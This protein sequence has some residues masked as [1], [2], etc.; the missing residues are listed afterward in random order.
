[1]TSPPVSQEI[2]G[3][4][5]SYFFGGTGPSHSKLTTAFLQGGYG[6]AC[7]YNVADGTP[8]KEIRVQRTI[9]AAVRK[10][11]RARGLVEALL[12]QLRIAGSFDSERTDFD[13]N[14]FRTLRKAFARQ[15]WSLSDDGELSPISGLDLTT[16]GRESLDEQLT[17]IRKATDDPG[18]LL[19]ASKDLL[20]AVAKFVLEE[21]GMAQPKSAKFPQLWHLSRERLGILPQQVDTTIPGADAIRHILQSAW[22]IA[23][24]VNV[25]RGLQGTGHGR[26]LP[27]GVSQELAL[28]VVREACSVA[29]FMLT[30]LDRQQGRRV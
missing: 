2:A 14:A 12:V 8:N 18:A 24:Q 1:M 22:T 10:P 26:T 17:R 9:M 6:D 3:A 23:D 15:G 19:G 25:L 21:V 16:G 13:R 4:F 29:E 27:T 5:A 28:M 11:D 30:T 20:E 7:P